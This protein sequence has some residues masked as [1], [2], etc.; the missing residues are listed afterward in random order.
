MP[1]KPG[2]SHCEK[3]RDSPGQ[4]LP[5]WTS[6]GWFQLVKTSVNLV[7][8][9]CR[10]GAC[11]DKQKHCKITPEGGRLRWL[12]IFDVHFIPWF[13]QC[14]LIFLPINWFSHLE[15]FLIRCDFSNTHFQNYPSARENKES[16]IEK[17]GS[18]AGTPI[19]KDRCTRKPHNCSSVL[20]TM[21]IL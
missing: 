20:L 17:N 13:L 5:V 18:L 6:L 21:A 10:I 12:F 3:G 11:S 1:A 7:H 19:G 14:L 16:E 2:D 15:T 8:C 9:C 4:E